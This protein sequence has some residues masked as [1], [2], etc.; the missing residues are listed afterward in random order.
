[1]FKKSVLLAALAAIGLTLG[2]YA[3]D[4]AMPEDD[5]GRADVVD[6]PTL[7]DG[8]ITARRAYSMPET[9]AG[10]YDVVDQPSLA[11]SGS[12]VGYRRAL[13]YAAPIYD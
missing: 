11:T 3:Q 7:S 9:D 13:R 10:R 2:V 1:M 6:Q 4:F 8:G 5:Y 12:E